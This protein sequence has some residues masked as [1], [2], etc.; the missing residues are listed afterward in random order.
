VNVPAKFK[1]RIAL[2][3]PEIIVIEVL[4]GVASPNLGEQEAIE[5]RGW[6]HSKER[7]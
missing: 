7:W 2:P 1:V 6:Y 3:I 5:G 4:G